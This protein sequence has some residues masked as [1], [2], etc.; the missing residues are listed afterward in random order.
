MT[1]ETTTLRQSRIG[2]RP[3]PV[4]AGVTATIKGT[5]VGLK[6]PKGASERTFG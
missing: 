6:G 5:T 2:K 4:P 1:T 3:V